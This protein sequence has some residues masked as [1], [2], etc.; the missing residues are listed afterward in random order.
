MF[1]LSSATQMQFHHPLLLESPFNIF[2]MDVFMQVNPTQRLTWKELSGWAWGKLRNATSSCKKNPS[3][4]NK[5][6]KNHSPEKKK[7]TNKTK[8]NS[9]PKKEKNKK[10]KN[11]P[12]TYPNDFSKY[13]SKCRIN[14]TYDSSSNHS[15]QHRETLRFVQ[16]QDF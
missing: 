8:S 3:K 14:C 9:P 1:H 6:T 13:N 4:Q 15:Q 7:S 2:S 5:K 16:S 11:P 12:K 10:K